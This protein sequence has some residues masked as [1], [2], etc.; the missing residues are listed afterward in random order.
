[1]LRWMVACAVM[2]AAASASAATVLVYGD[3]LSAGYGLPREQGWVSLLAQ[4]LRAENSDYKVANASISGETTVG[5]AQRID[6]ALKQHRPAVVILALGAND[7]LR[8]ASLD[9]VRGNLEAII[10]ASHRANARVLLVGMR[11]PPN[12]GT[13]YTERFQ[14]VFDEIA[15]ARKLPLVPFLLEGFAEKPEYFQADGIHPTAAGQPLMLETVWKK[16]RLLIK[17]GETGN[18]K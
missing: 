4:R 8:G 10:A 1:M 3:S 16:L 2:L 15:T 13:Q 9:A 12:Y 14:R 11:L 17:R 5:G 18:R 6:A 7:G